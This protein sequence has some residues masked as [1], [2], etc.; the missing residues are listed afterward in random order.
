MDVRLKPREQ[1]Q[2]G[3]AYMGH[4]KRG[5]SSKTVAKNYHTRQDFHKN[6]QLSKRILQNQQKP[7]WTQ[8]LQIR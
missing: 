2:V 4:C 6:Q 7:N 5:I 3:A 1:N 8:Q